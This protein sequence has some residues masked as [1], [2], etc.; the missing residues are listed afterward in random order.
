MV[1][2]YRLKDGTEIREQQEGVFAIIF[3][4]KRYILVRTWEGRV[5]LDIPG[6]GRCID[7]GEAG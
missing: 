3:P 4:N 2:H 1:R 6:F 5:E 7:L